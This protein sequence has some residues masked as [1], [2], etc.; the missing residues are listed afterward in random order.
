MISR[1][2]SKPSFG[3][4]VVYHRD[5]ITTIVANHIETRHRTPVRGD[6]E[7]AFGTFEKSPRSVND[8]KLER[9]SVG[10]DSERLW[11]SGPRIQHMGLKRPYPI[12]PDFR[13]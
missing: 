10:F 12:N 3:G 2:E 6:F 4:G 7:Y 13:N 5:G 8:L 9:A 1:R 11:K